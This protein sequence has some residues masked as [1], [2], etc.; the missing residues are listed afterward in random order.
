MFFDLTNYWA[1]LVAASFIY[2]VVVNFMQNNIGGKGRMRAI[3]KEMG[4]VQ[5]KMFEAAKKPGNDPDSAENAEKYNK[6]TF[7]MMG[8]QLKMTVVLLA[9]FFPLV[10]FVF[11]A[12]EPNGQDDTRFGLFDD[13]LIAHCD[14]A[15]GDGI[16]SG[17]L[18]LP[19]GGVRGAW[20]V[21]AHMNSS[22]G[23]LLARQGVAVYYEGG[24]PEDIWLQSFSQAG[25]LDGVTGKQPYVLYAAADKPI[26]KS[27]ETAKI[28]ARPFTVVSKSGNS[29]NDIVAS[30]GKAIPRPS[31]DE[32]ARISSFSAS[33]N[34]EALMEIGG[35]EYLFRK[36]AALLGEDVSVG[37]ESVPQG[38]IFG[39]SSNSGTFFY[40]DLPF[41]LPLLNIRR[42]IGSYG[43]FIF[44]AFIM[45]IAYNMA[46]SAY[47]K[48][49]KK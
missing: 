46:N 18:Q 24:K 11:P 45:G 10:S 1:F 41:P 28:S 8:V 22:Q 29:L 35:K 26:Y 9:L 20:M 13:G 34:S 49:A 23:E 36:H 3:Q 5:K 27:G 40:V 21:D 6:L 16:F 44:F 31:D 39:A 12:L 43:V 48:A 19:A 32:I 7:E 17:C 47:Q 30:L 42:I 33:K 14:S 25:L 15:S 37:S 4:E 38:A 2:I